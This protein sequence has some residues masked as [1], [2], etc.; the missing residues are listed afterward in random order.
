M[1]SLS[2]LVL[3]GALLTG[4]AQAA[5]QH[6]TGVALPPA[7]APN[8]TLTSDT[9]APWTLAAQHGKVVALFFGFTHCADTCPAT[10]AKLAAALHRDNAGARAE[11][12]FVTIDPQRD[13]P[14][15]MHAYIRRFSGATIVGLTG[16]AAQI[17][18]IERAYNVWS[19]PVPDPHGGTDYDEEHSAFTFLI[20]RNGNWRVVHS[21]DDAQRDYVADLRELLQS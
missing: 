4:C 20:D 13:T 17:A 18:T 6:F 21:D 3:A 16:T 14:A 8:F 12:A 11:I 7:P 10:L 19:K 15:V 2:A 1:R 5:A 9:G